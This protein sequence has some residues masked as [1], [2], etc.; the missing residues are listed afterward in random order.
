MGGRRRG[1]AGPARAFLPLPPNAFRP[2]F[3]IVA[4]GGGGGEGASGS[5]PAYSNSNARPPAHSSGRRRA[6]GR[7]HGFRRGRIEFAADD[8]CT[9]QLQLGR[10]SE[11]S[12]V[13]GLAESASGQARSSERGKTGLSNRNQY[14][15]VRTEA[16]HL[17]AAYY[18]SSAGGRTS[19]VF[20]SG[21]GRNHRS[22]RR[23]Y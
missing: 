20:Q 13:P 21:L 16:G 4:P 12:V 19:G 10:S 14:G 15:R 7:L 1:G 9:R 5:T 18:G 3:R 2:S 17:D 6:E 8:V 11:R 23:R 22:R